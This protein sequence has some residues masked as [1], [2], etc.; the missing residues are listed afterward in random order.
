M[1]D[2]QTRLLQ[3][4]LVLQKVHFEMGKEHH[5]RELAARQKMADYTANIGKRW[6][7]PMILSIAAYF[8][9]TFVLAAAIAL[10]LSKVS[11]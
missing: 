11:T 3:E 5:E 10:I 8:L 1:S 6:R 7:G 9:F 2:E 4:I